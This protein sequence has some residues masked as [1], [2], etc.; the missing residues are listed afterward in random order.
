MDPEGALVSSKSI[1]TRLK[2]QAEDSINKQIQQLAADVRR[3]PRKYA[4]DKSPWKRDPVTGELPP[5]PT[6]KVT[7]P[8]FRLR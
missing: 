3:N 2:K 1:G 6:V 8:K 5:K 4:K 7:A